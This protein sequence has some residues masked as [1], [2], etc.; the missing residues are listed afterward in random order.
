MIHEGPVLEFG[1]R[2]LALLQWSAALATGS[3]SC[4]LLRSS[5]PH[6]E[7]VWL[8]L[9]LLPVVLVVL[10]GALALVETLVAKMRI[11]LAPR[12]ISGRRRSRAPRHPHLADRDDVT[13][14]VAWMLVASGTRRRR[15]ATALGRRR[16]RH[17][18]GPGSRA[19]GAR[20]SGDDR[21]RRRERS[22]RTARR[23]SRRC[24]SQEPL[25]RRASAF[26]FMRASHHSC[27]AVSAVLLRSRA[28]LARAR[29][30][31]RVA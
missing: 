12:L 20:R 21:R 5:L 10:C 29:D 3:C 6:A 30:R 27:A 8:Q 14:F 26:R 13:G 9:A 22:A 16:H 18:A 1:G 25:P 15:R 31:A 4:S 19:S 24:S 7:S 17:R 11:L 23:S 2:D 28:R